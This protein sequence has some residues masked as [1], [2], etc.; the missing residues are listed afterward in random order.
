MVGEDSRIPKL[1]N[2]LSSLKILDIALGG[3][4]TVAVAS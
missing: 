4:F 1:V 3:Y 2:A